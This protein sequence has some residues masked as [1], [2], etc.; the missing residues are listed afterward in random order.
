MLAFQVMEKGLQ[1]CGAAGVAKP[2]NDAGQVAAASISA[3]RA[4]DV[5]T[6]E[7]GARPGTKA[8]EVGAALDGV[9]AVV[10]DLTGHL[11]FALESNY[12]EFPDG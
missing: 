11:K 7:A 1:G 6:H 12:P 9:Q 8:H 10:A 5:R 2:G 4:D 3:E